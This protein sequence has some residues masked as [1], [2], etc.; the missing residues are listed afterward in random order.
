M[1][2]CYWSLFRGVCEAWQNLLFSV[3]KVFVALTPIML[4][5]AWAVRS[6]CSNPDQKGILTIEHNIAIPAVKHIPLLNDVLI[7]LFP[8]NGDAY[9]P[10]LASD[11]CR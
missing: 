1:V 8:Q 5:L 7:V 10:C 11:M 6:C 9:G 3:F 2:S 4:F